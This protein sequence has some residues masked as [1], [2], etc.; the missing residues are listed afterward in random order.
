[1]KDQN[2]S[3][4]RPSLLLRPAGK[5]VS[6]V[7]LAQVWVYPP[8]VGLLHKLQKQF[9]S[10]LEEASAE[11]VFEEYLA[12]AP[13]LVD[14]AP[15]EERG[16]TI[17]QR[18]QLTE[19]DKVALAIE[20]LAFFSD[21]R[22]GDPPIHA[23][24][25]VLARESAKL[26][27]GEVAV[28]AQLKSLFGNDSASLALF[29]ESQRHS[30]IIKQALGPL[31]ALSGMRAS[32]DFVKQVQGPY[33]DL[34]EAIKQTTTSAS[35][36]FTPSVDSPANNLLREIELDVHQP[37]EEPNGP[38][39]AHQV[40][41]EA[42]GEQVIDLARVVTLRINELAD[43]AQAF[44]IDAA[45][46]TKKSLKI[47]MIALI[48]SALLSVAQLGYQVWK[49]VGDGARSKEQ[50]TLLRETNAA[51]TQQINLMRQMVEDTRR[52]RDALAKALAKKDVVPGTAPSGGKPLAGIRTDA[53]AGK[54]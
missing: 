14:R 46:S 5:M 7:G 17:E 45:A 50:M 47:A 52:E 22:Q 33:G 25:K 44:Q 34:L 43:F 35:P 20:A 18:G 54:K 23:L 48:V 4:K 37:P 41:L 32:I 15:S 49:D 1:M 13:A 24:V 3:I 38:T 53:H 42:A 26:R 31:E 40:R 28:S 10:E 6:T 51:S 29:K 30:E 2:D 19:G 16:L 12:L 27:D 9:G 21:V 36:D 11:A 8:T 39:R